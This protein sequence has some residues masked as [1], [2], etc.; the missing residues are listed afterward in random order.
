VVVSFPKAETVIITVQQT[1]TKKEKK[2]K[3][4]KKTKYRGFFFFFWPQGHFFRCRHERKRQPQA[5]L[6]LYIY[7]L[8]Q[9]QRQ[10]PIL[11]DKNNDDVRWLVGRPESHFGKSANVQMF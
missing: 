6:S 10:L 4:K 1:T 7:F 11:I 2:K 5:G 8:T 9:N 3:K